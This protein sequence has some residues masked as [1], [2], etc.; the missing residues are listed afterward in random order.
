MAELA[1][2][3][4]IGE[5]VGIADVL[6]VVAKHVAACRARLLVIPA[7]CAP[8]VV[9]EDSPG[10]CQQILQSAIDCWVVHEYAMRYIVRYQFASG[11]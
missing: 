7:R 5:V 3:E 4:R 1:L 11:D 6:R 10:T 2:A 8:L 9:N